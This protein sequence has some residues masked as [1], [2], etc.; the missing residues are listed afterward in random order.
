MGYETKLILTLIVLHLV[1]W[2]YNA[3]VAWLEK[4]GYHDGFVSLMVVLG[5]GYTVL[6][7]A[8]IIGPQALV[9]LTLAFVASGTP[10]IVGSI[11]RYI[12]ERRAEDKCLLDHARKLNGNGQ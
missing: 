6:A 10:M 3:L 2:G 1:S 4:K 9:T 5:V 12:A 8:W 7:T 11:A